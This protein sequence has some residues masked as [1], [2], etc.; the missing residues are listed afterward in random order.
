MN[1]YER[2]MWERVDAANERNAARLLRTYAPGNPNWIARE[3]Y[4]RRMAIEGMKRR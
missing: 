2:Q 4:L 1:D 3:K